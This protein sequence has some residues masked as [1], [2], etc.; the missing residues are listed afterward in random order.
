MINDFF[1]LYIYTC[2]FFIDFVSIII[3]IIIIK[4]LFRNLE[5]TYEITKEI[6]T[7]NYSSKNENKNSYL[8]RRKSSQELHTVLHNLAEPVI[9]S[10]PQN[11][12]ISGAN[13]SKHI[14]D[15]N[16]HT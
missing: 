12:T 6:S 13:T 1:F 15:I 2:I 10:R 14:Y 9:H 8:M 7:K 3:I 5:A 11:T 4:T 16:I